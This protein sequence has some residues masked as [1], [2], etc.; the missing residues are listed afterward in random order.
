M[1]DLQQQQQQKEQHYL[2]QQYLTSVEFIEVEKE[3]SH[4]AKRRRYN[5]TTQHLL[6]EK[7][8]FTYEVP[9]D[10]VV[11]PGEDLVLSVYFKTVPGVDV[12]WNVNGFELKDSKKVKI[13]SDEEHSTLV[14]LP[15]IRCGNYNVTVTNK[16]GT[17]NHTTHVHYD[18]GKQKE[19]VKESRLFSNEITEHP[20]SAYTTTKLFNGWELVDEQQRSSKSV[21]SFETVKYVERVRAATEGRETP[22]LCDQ[23]PTPHQSFNSTYTVRQNGESDGG[24]STMS[25]ETTTIPPQL[26]SKPMTP[27]IHEPL[28]GQ[29]V[30]II[31]EAPYSS[32]YVEKRYEEIISGISKSVYEP[33]LHKSL[34]EQRYEEAVRTGSEVMSPAVPSTKSQPQN[35]I[36]EH[37]IVDNKTF[38]IPVQRTVEQIPKHPFILKQPEPEIRLKAGEKLVLESKVDS[39]PASQFKWYQNNFEVRPSPSVIIESSA[40]N[41][42][43]ATFLKPI[44]GTYKMVASNIHGSCSSTTRVV[45]EVT[46]EWTAESSI[47][48]IRTMPEKQEPNYQLIK[49]P[50]TV[51]RND[52]PK[53]PRIMERF[54]PLLKIANNEPLVLRVTADAIPEAEFRWMLNN[55][56]IR[57]S[58]AV[59]IQNLGP[60]VSQI[61]FHSPISGR[62]EVVAMNSL[63]QDSCSAKVIIDYEE[64]VQIIPIKPVERPT[65]PKVPVFIKPLPGETQLYSEEQEFRLSVLVNGEKPIT[66]R[67]FAD[68]SLLSNSVE[69]Q[70]INDSESSTL[71][72]R[73]QIGCDVDYAVEVSNANGA[74]WSETTVRPPLFTTSLATNTTSPES[75]LPE[76]YDAQR[77]SPRYTAVLMDKNLQQNDEFTAYVA[78]SAESSPCEFTWT[79]NGRD[80]RTIPGFRV[81]ST[82]YESTLYIKSALLKHSGEL[83]VIASNKYGTAKSSAKITVHPC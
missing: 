41:E 32:H 70:M 48:T 5:E 78:V 51:T 76:I 25:Y 69:H 39:Y 57:T 68:G 43:R 12:K 73:K 24:R 42:S 58:Q 66:F 18:E 13:I 7:P 38:C 62:Y 77:C 9:T 19:K 27:I 8:V 16:Y 1:N 4:A 82:F 15:P 37:K 53:P 75:S 52:L 61:T 72:V 64:E 21:D 63:G 10:V 60:N 33:M 6:H 28:V 20:V 44:S 36:M 79:L 55:F 71:V 80:I 26:L 29:S 14:C 34:T 17:S 67:W 46:E 3:Q 35:E 47:S 11:G 65:V 40:V 45:T 54:A 74:V 59:D 81:G 49:R 31:P 50:Y 23:T 30:S 56:E 83:S 22:I 2:E